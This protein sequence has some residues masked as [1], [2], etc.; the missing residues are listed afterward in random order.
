VTVRYSD[1]DDAAE[2]ERLQ[3]E[4]RAWQPDVPLEVLTTHK[5]SLTRPMVDYLNRL[6][7][8]A[9]AS[10][11]GFERI[12]VLIPEVE[13]RR[14]WHRLLHNQRGVVLDRAIRRHT[15]AIVCRMRFHIKGW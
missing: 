7:A 6:E 10:P 2:C 13:P 14:A 15:E 12:M 5:R 1:E 3:A 4:W 9:P 8:S 11:G